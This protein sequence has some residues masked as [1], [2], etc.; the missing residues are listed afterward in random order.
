MSRK[1][2]LGIAFISAV[3]AS[4]FVY[5]IY[6]MQLK[7]MEWQDTIQVAAPKQFIDAGTLLTPDLIEYKTIL[8]GGYEEG[9]ILDLDEVLGKEAVVPLGE[10]EPILS[11]KLNHFHLM[12]QG[13]E[14]TFQIPN[15]YILSVSN[16]I[17]AGDYVELYLSSADGSSRKLFSEPV[18][19]ASVKMA[20]NQEVEDGA[21]SSLLSRARGDLERL[22]A[23]RRNANGPIDQ[24]N[25]N[26]TEEQ[27]LEIDRLCKIDGNQLVIAYSNRKPKLLETAGN[28]GV[29]NGF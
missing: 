23:S 7:H 12:P 27:W 1:K 21:N 5:A 26:L 15:A 18:V 2:S 9:M 16:Q 24:I 20:S 22:Y 13:N 19:V 29:K 4:G 17:R 6:V 11:W 8:A 25:L 28:G 10:G 3:L 14:S